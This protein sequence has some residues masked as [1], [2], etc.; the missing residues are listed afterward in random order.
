MSIHERSRPRHRRSTTL[1]SSGIKTGDR[2]RAGW[3]AVATL[4][5]LDEYPLHLG[6]ERAGRGLNPADVS[7]NDYDVVIA[8]GGI[9]GLTAGL[10]GARAGRKTRVLTGPTL[11]GHLLSIERIDGYPVFLAGIFLV[12]VIAGIRSL[13]WKA[14]WLVAAGCLWYFAGPFF[15]APFMIFVVLRTATTVGSSAR[16]RLVSP[17]PVLPQRVHDHQDHAQANTVVAPVTLGLTFDARSCG[18]RC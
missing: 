10:L 6:L 2:T 8:G 7:D 1:P 17:L 16:S 14:I 4:R 5:H 3:L 13:L 12:A 9:A 18:A 15:A 11:G